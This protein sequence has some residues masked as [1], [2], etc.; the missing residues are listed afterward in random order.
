MKIALHLL[1]TLAAVLIAAVTLPSTLFLSFT[2]PGAA[3]V[4]LVTG[5][6]V[7][8]LLLGW[9]GRDLAWGRPHPIAE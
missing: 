9:L 6:G 8:A 4:L 2:H 1:A 7:P 3:A 5:L